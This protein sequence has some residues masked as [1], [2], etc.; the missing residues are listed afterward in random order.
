MDTIQLP[1]HQ[2]SLTFSKIMTSSPSVMGSCMC[3]WGV[4]ICMYGCM[5]VCMGV[6]EYVCMGVWEY[7]C[8]GVL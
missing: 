5:G 8:M 3:V 4:G 1:H 6:W 7:V 2:R